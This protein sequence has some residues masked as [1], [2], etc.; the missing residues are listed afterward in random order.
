MG[1]HISVN[2]WIHLNVK[3]LNGQEI[4]GNPH[5]CKSVS[6]RL[7]LP[8][9]DMT[10]KCLNPNFNSGNSWSDW[11]RQAATRTAQNWTDD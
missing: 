9:M 4:S 5:Q 2:E 8:E 3:G 1:L 10:W 6:D 7:V 11:K